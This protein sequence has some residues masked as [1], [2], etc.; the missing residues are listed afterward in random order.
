[1]PPK[2]PIDQSFSLGVIA[3]H[4]V[5]KKTR[6]GRVHFLFPDSRTPIIEQPWEEHHVS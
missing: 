6:E 3:D 5:T 2:P 4:F 1:M